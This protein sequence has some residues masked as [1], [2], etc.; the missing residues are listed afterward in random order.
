MQK[1]FILGVGAQKAGT[2]WLHRQFQANS[3]FNLGHRKEYHVFDS[4][5][6]LNNPT[7][8]KGKVLQL[9]KCIQNIIESHEQGTLGRNLGTR[10]QA[11]DLSFI[12]NIE[13]Y[14]D[15]FDYLFLKSHETQVVG[16]IT[17]EYA[18]L[19][20]ETFQLIKNGLENRGFNVKVIFLMRDPIE[21]AWS[22]AR[23]RKR[24]MPKDKQEKINEFSFLKQR[25]KSGF[26]TKSKYDETIKNLESIFN[27]DNLHYDF[28]ERLFDEGSHQRIQ[29][30]LNSDL[31]KFDTSQV[32]NASPKSEQNL[33]EE[34]HQKLMK[35]FK[36]T[37]D[38]MKQR[39]GNMITDIW[40]GY[41]SQNSN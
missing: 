15:Y 28:Y 20:P 22:A 9:N 34:V 7:K 29:Q 25:S 1:T 13:N 10:Y 16:D 12:D 41:H 36:P 39:Y 5:E 24:N 19:Q 14:F 37:Y 3:T 18:L 17:P 32:I 40:K 31:R 4:I 21:R 30:F 6:K 8:K 26:I 33:P 11:K 35:H 38:F 27:K 2:T 23:Y